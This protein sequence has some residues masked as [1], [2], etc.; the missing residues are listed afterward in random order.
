MAPVRGED[1][2]GKEGKALKNIA[3]V[4]NGPRKG[5]I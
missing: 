1:L 3:Q 5:K 2:T 4:I